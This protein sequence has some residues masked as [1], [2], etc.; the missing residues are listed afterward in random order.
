MYIPLSQIY[1]SDLGFEMEMRF[2]LWYNLGVLALL[3]AL[4]GVLPYTW[5]KEL[6]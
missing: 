4:L 5:R 1:I 3:G 6:R 2:T